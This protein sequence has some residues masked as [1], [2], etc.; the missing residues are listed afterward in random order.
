M[1]KPEAK[2]NAAAVVLAVLGASGATPPPARAQ[3]RDV[4]QAP[5]AA[6]EG[7]RKSLA[8]QIGPGRG[9]G[10]T[11][12][13]SSFVIAR[14]AFRAIRRGRQLFQRKFTVAQGLGPTTLDGTGEI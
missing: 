14:D 5:N 7:I 12:G 10:L 4:T 1:L 11:P 2:R 9:D 13:S 8:A 3:L 6:N